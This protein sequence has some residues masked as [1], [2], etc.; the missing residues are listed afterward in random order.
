VKNELAQYRQNPTKL[1]N[2]KAKNKQKTS[3]IL[4]N[5]ALDKIV[6][7]ITVL[8]INVEFQPF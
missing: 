8:E 2:Q 7:Q 1:S 5:Q 6:E 4:N 3:I